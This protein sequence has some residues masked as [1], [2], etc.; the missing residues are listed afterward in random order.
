MDCTADLT[1][2]RTL[3]FLCKIKGQTH[4]HQLPATEQQ[5]DFATPGTADMDIVGKVDTRKQDVYLRL[6][7]YLL[8][9]KGMKKQ[10]LH[11]VRV[12][13]SDLHL[14]LFCQALS[15]TNQEASQILGL[16]NHIFFC[17]RQVRL[18]YQILL[19]RIVHTQS[20]SSTHN[21][22]KV[23][24][25]GDP[26]TSTISNILSHLGWDPLACDPMHAPCLHLSVENLSTQHVVHMYGMQLDISPV[27][28]VSLIL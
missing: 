6:K 4:S 8:G 20:C 26:F 1:G 25:T 2:K 15:P 21:C 24:G 22:S 11:L 18:L 5:Q 17:M 28:Y 14:A 16:R 12:L 13:V 9:S 7:S 3:G 10:A 23:P 27:L 19:M